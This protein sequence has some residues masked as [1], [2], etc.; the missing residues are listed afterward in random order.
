MVGEGVGSFDASAGKCVSSFVKENC[1]QYVGCLRAAK[2]DGTFMAQL[3]ENMY[4]LRFLFL[5]CVLWK[6]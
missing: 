4:F 3:G 2:L 1:F 5:F 6:I